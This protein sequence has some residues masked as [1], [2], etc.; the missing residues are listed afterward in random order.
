VSDIKVGM[1]KEGLVFKGW[2]EMKEE[3]GLGSQEYGLKADE[4]YLG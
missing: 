2:N 1:K 4:F 3:Y